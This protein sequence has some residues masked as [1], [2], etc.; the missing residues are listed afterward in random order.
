MGS[1]YRSFKNIF[2]VDYRAFTLALYDIK[3][4]LI[5]KTFHY[6]GSKAKVNSP[7]E[8]RP[9]VS[10]INIFIVPAT[11]NV[12]ICWETNFSNENTY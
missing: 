8:D 5:L 9:K 6:P 11:R 4:T 1:R 10:K 3:T 12:S 7:I 2:N